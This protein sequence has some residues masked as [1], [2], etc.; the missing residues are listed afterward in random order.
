MTYDLEDHPQPGALSS[1]TT[2]EDFCHPANLPASD[3]CKEP[4][5]VVLRIRLSRMFSGEA[6][7]DHC[8]GILALADRHPAAGRASVAYEARY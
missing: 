8:V 2:K 3:C 5:R 6:H 7:L 4:T 1:V